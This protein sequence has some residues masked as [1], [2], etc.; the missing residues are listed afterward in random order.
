LSVTLK[1]DFLFDVDSS[2]VHTGAY[3]EIDHL[4]MP[5]TRILIEGP[6]DRPG[7]EE[8]NL[9]LSQRRAEPVNG[10]LASKVVYPDRMTA[11][12]YRE[13]R[14]RAL[15]D[16]LHGRQFNRRVDIYIEPR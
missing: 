9:H 15:N 8:Y 10:Y 6:T 2:V 1:G 4:A 11:I 3:S 13:S 7:P 5:D 16:A 12:G 14:P